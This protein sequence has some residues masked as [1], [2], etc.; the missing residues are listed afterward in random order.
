MALEM[1]N[2]LRRRRDCFRPAVRC[3]CVAALLLSTAA[4]GVAETFVVNMINYEFI[5]K[6]ITIQVGDTIEWPNLDEDFHTTTSGTTSGNVAIPSGVWDSGYYGPKGTY[7]FTFNVPPGLYPY[8]CLPHIPI[9][10]LGTVTVL[11]ASGGGPW[12]LSQPQSRE[13]GVGA[14]VTFRVS[15]GGAA[16]LAYQWQANGRE[17]P[18]ATNEILVLSNA[19]P[20]DAGAYV[21]RVSNGGGSV[22]SEPA[23][24]TVSAAIPHPTASITRPAAG[25]AFAMGGGVGLV[26]A[27]SSAGATIA[28]V[29]FFANQAPLGVVAAEP[30]ELTWRP[31][32]PGN[33]LLTAVA[34]DSLGQA[35]T[36]APVAIRV[37]FPETRPP[38]V[39]V[40]NSPPQYARLRTSRVVL[41]GTAADNFGVDRVQVRVN[42]GPAAS[43]AGT[44]SW[45]AEINLAPGNNIITIT[46]VD[47][48]GNASAPVSRYLTRVAQAPLG[49][50]MEG[51]GAVFPNLDGLALEIGQVYTVHA[52]PEAGFL[53]AGWTG[54]GR[55]HADPRLRFQM[56]SNL[57]LA[58]RFV[59]NRFR[60]VAG[61][62]LGL[63]SDS[64]TAV[65]SRMGSFALQLAGAGAFSGKLMLNGNA[66]SFRGQF[67][68]E[69]RAALVV[70]RRG[71]A[72]LAFVMALD[73]DRGVI[74]GSGS[75]GGADLTLR[76]EGRAPGDLIPMAASPFKLR[77]RS[78]REGETLAE[79]VITLGSNGAVRLAGRFA[80]GRAFSLASA[81]VRGGEVPVYVHAGRPGETLFGWLRHAADE[82][83]PIRG[84]LLWLQDGGEGAEADFEMEREAGLRVGRVNPRPW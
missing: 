59:T 17:L 12:I 46:S 19:Q 37:F 49:L 34:F 51:A 63:C 22:L 8:Y 24:L 48:A 18:G 68:P 4:P 39:R 79:G 82:E 28:G 70:P 14:T 9:G 56:E 16:P 30:F 76:A 23:I 25:G 44:A 42:G 53:F 36:S 38:A 50:R 26:A 10:M 47:Q 29:A 77:G 75:D 80:D 40:T 62:Y 41:A 43:A 78:G 71:R 69:G 55:A 33:Y 73:F 35:G 3:L 67:D 74:S 65:G 72:P 60:S 84:S 81:V 58:A 27:A 13:V 54:A 20:A 11:P 15:A 2:K 57:V 64:S 5:P 7:S 66:H 83:A 1:L 52:R 31:L 61:S 21:V 6:D 32:L 45:R